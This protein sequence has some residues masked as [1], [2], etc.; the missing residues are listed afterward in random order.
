MMRIRALLLVAFAPAALLTQCSPVQTAHSGGSGSEVVGVLVTKTGA[1]VSGATVVIDTSIDPGDTSLH[2][3]TS[4][5]HRDTAVSDAH[6]KFVLN[7]DS[8]EKNGVFNVTC[9]YNKGTLVAVIPN[10]KVDS[11]YVNLG[12]DTMLA[13]GKI[14]GKV[15]INNSSMTG[16]ICYI[17]GTSFLAMSDD[18]GGFTIS[19]VPPGT[20]SVYFYMAGY[21]IGID[22]AVVVLSNQT[23]PAQTKIL[24]LDPN[25]APP[26]PVAL[27]AVEDT[28]D[29]IVRISW[30]KLNVSD[31]SGY[32]VFRK[33][34]GNLG[35]VRIGA[36]LPQTDTFFVDTVFKTNKDTTSHLYTYSVEAVDTVPNNSA[37]ASPVELNVVPPFYVRPVFWLSIPN[38]ASDTANTGD[39]VRVTAWFA[40]M[41]A[42]TDTVAWFTGTPRSP[43][44]KKTPFNALRGSDTFAYTWTASGPKNVY[45]QAIDQHGNSWF[46]SISL[47]LR[48]HSVDVV[49]AKCTDSSITL[50]W[51]MSSEPAFAGYRIFAADTSAGGMA[52]VATTVANVQDTVYTFAKRKSGFLRYSV[53]VAASNGLS[54]N[55]GKSA[56]CAIVNTPPKMAVDTS[57]IS[58]VASVGSLYTVKLAATDINGDSL[59]F[60]LVAPAVGMSIRDSVL[61]WTPTM[62]D[63]GNK[64]VEIVV[65]DGFGGSD[66]VQWSVS[67]ALK[68]WW[69]AA[70]SL[71]TARRLLSLVAV[72]GA[73][74]A[75]G[76]ELTHLLSNGVPVLTPYA[77][78]ESY[79][80]GGAAW[81]Q[82]APL[83]AARYWMACASVN[84]TIYAF[85]G[86]GSRDYVTS[87]DSLA[88]PGDA[89]GA[90]GQLT[91]P[92]FDASACEVGGTVYVVGGQ[93]SSGG[94]IVGTS[95]IDAWDP[96]T[97]SLTT[98]QH[99]KMPRFDHQTVV[100]NGKIYIIG[101]NGGITVPYE[102]LKSVEVYDPQSNTMDT[103]APLTMPRNALAAAVANGRIYAIGGQGPTIDI[104]TALASVEI[105]DPVAN[106]WSAGQ[107][108]PNGR[109]G[110]AAASLNGT[111]YVAGGVEAGAGG[112]KETSSVI[113]YYP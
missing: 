62:L 26:P 99:M 94:L 69:T 98:R 105:Y 31:L 103:V 40:S 59:S 30:H 60:A 73:L 46:D 61:L 55:P 13:P 76:G 29:G 80:A 84:N 77:T 9:N 43:F 112:N 75:M 23:T 92:R 78:V 109:Y 18:T 108:M 97:G 58:K 51:R 14:S 8:A 63:T 42:Q 100:L 66:T 81:T 104:D 68:N 72:N 10:V 15:V 71:S 111:I 24:N 48:P 57:R 83:S 49:S 44:L 35:Y 85:G 17:P 36:Q 12:K 53:V 86:S 4:A 79:T 93:T 64:H 67:V 70:P 20:Y 19:G 22:T 50:V 91:A 34:P 95:E 5:I 54:S 89:W 41:L 74:Y 21:Q 37:Y 102:V 65:A 106:T 96:V 87:V 56:V 33:N 32:Y 101:G 90:T 1:P 16:V 88:T 28:L 52:S 2:L 11:A 107:P 110:C 45:V 27:V 3:D 7:L 39:T 113:V 82:S 6:G 25:G 47:V 38:A